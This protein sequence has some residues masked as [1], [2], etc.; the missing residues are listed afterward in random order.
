MPLLQGLIRLFRVLMV[1]RKSFDGTV[2][3]QKKPGS[4]LPGRGF[5]NKKGCVH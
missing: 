3:V 1:G 2:L 4:G 5:G